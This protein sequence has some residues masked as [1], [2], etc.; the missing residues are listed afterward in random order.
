MKL[1]LNKVISKLPWRFSLRTLLIALTAV[2][3][4]L[5]VLNSRFM[6]FRRQSAAMAKLAGRDAY[7]QVAWERAEPRWFWDRV[8]RITG[9][10]CA[11]VV[12]LQMNKRSDAVDAD[13]WQQLPRLRSLDIHGGI[14]DDVVLEKLSQVG[15]I[16]KLYLWLRPGVPG[17]FSYPPA[18]SNE[19]VKH[20][21]KLKRLRVL[22]L[23]SGVLNGLRV[24]DDGFEPV[25]RAGLPL[26]QLDIQLSN[27][28][29]RSLRP[30]LEQGTLQTVYLPRTFVKDIDAILEYPTPQLIKINGMT[31]SQTRQDPKRLSID[32]LASYFYE[33]ELELRRVDW[34]YNVNVSGDEDQPIAD[35]FHARSV[36]ADADPMTFQI[37]S[38]PVAGGT[39]RLNAAGTGFIYLPAHDYNGED[40]FTYRAFDGYDYSNEKTVRVTIYPVNDSPTAQDMTSSGKANATIEDEFLATD[41]DG[42]ELVFE[43]VTTAA[44]GGTVEGGNV[45]GGT[46]MLN[47]AGR[48]GFVFTPALNFHGKS[49][50]TYR[51]YDGY[52]YSAVKTV[53][54]T[55]HPASDR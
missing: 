31:Y 7:L 14:T 20:L 47:D 12:G 33:H 32:D 17:P 54:I 24:N 4:L 11:F 18:P 1:L 13:C 55:I 21:A 19:G 9:M 50:F 43:I 36:Y 28:T 42:D 16:E 49:S 23:Q 37:V 38:G 10:H 15:T 44:S 35:N 3:V 46:V 26:E 45:E 40:T 51:A 41:V 27:I 29:I 5:S 25:A 53:T 8:E 48:T 39:V 2:C 52:E 30:L 22:M 34:A 6:Q